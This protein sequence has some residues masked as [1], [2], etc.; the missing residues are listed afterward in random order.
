MEKNPAL[1][2]GY[3][4]FNISEDSCPSVFSVAL[5]LEMGGVFRCPPISEAEENTVRNG[6]LPEQKMKQAECFLMT[7]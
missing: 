3:G 1:L 6:I 2:Y 5:W 4:G 7:S